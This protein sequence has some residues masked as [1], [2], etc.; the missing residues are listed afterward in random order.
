MI[1]Q[2][3]HRARLTALFRRHEYEVT[4]EAGT[5]GSVILESEGKELTDRISVRHRENLLLTV[6][7][8]FGQRIADVLLDSVSILGDVTLTRRGGR[9]LLEKVTAKHKI[10]VTFEPKTYTNGRKLFDYWPPVIQRIRDMQEIARVQ[11]P[12]I[13]ELWDSLSWLMESQFIDTA[14]EEAVKIWEAELGVIPNASDTLKQRKARLKL[15][16]VPCSRFTIR[17]LHHWL[18]D[19]T[20]RSD[21]L[22]P[23]VPENTYGLTVH[24]PYD[25]DWQT[26]F[27]DLERY[28]PCNIYLDPHVDLQSSKM[29]VL[30]GFAVGS[31]R[32]VVIKDEKQAEREESQ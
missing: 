32:T 7:A 24:L 17:W 9:Y 3:L 20:Q 30:A 22:R 27:G 31:K 1:V 28:K 5:G 23:V 12:V 26:I 15:K 25:A 18:C 13:D 4:A 16:W 6:T 14:T 29:R 8:D 2:Q 21:I 10:V 11:Q 19:V